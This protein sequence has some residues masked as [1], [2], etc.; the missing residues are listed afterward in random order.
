[1]NTMV[2][3]LSKVFLFISISIFIYIFSL[4]SLYVSHG[5]DI[6]DQ[7]FNLLNAMAPFDIFNA[8]SH[9]RYYTSMLYYLSGENLGLYRFFGTF[10]LLGI[11]FWF[12][13]ELHKYISEKLNKTFS[14]FE[15][16]TF[17]IPLMTSSLAFYKN[18]QITPS[19][20]WLA[21][22]SV[23][24]FFIS[25][26][27]IVRKKNILH[28]RWFSFDYFLL[29]FSLSLSFMAKPTTALVLA[30]IAILFLLYELKNIHTKYAITSVTIMTA[31]LVI[32]HIIFLDGGVSEYFSK[33][34]VGLERISLLGGG[35]T[36]KERFADMTEL[37]YAIYRELKQILLFSVIFILGLF[38][39]QK[40]GKNKKLISDR[41]LFFYFFIYAVFISQQIYDNQKLLWI[42]FLSF[43]LFALGTYV[44]Y[45]IANKKSFSFKGDKVEA[46]FLILIFL[47]V[48]GSIAYAF[49]TNNN[50]VSHM[51]KSIIF[52]SASILL[53]SHI[54]L[55]NITE[56]QI[57]ISFSG[58]V[59][60]CFV[61]YQVEQGFYKP[62]RLET[63]MN[64]QNYKIELQ[65]E[66][67][68]D[69]KH[70]KY[71]EDLQHIAKKYKKSDSLYLID[72]TGG[73]PAANIILDM[74]FF[75][76]PWLLG[77]YKGSNEFAYENL[78][79][80]K[81]TKELKTAWILTAPNGR[82]KLDLKILNMI[83]LNFP[84]DYKKIGIVKTAHRN[85]IQ[86][87]WKPND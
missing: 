66:I 85:E 41:F 24:L 29:S 19:Y 59:I 2:D 9:E 44:I 10:I 23:I 73:T 50:I 27:R 33:L 14:V 71:I 26:F 60:S 83:G 17:I 62:Y 45:L 6:T 54:Y 55:K 49:G 42:K 4:L 86:E 63:P 47:I 28:G 15:K 7:S 78:K 84:S 67:Y 11:S 8:I 69:K 18:W 13:I 37:F 30:F 20:N 43:L 82:R 64:E 21:L 32:G 52:L 31:L 77:A 53:F 81:D 75:S 16:L 51:S 70:K 12:A 57:F 48:L 35:H 46:K 79:S 58:M 34:S 72:L 36:L 76:A 65:G 5:F 74:K 25:L 61:L 68:V 87:L 40:Y 39:I 56:N 3:K 38:F 80:Y 1:M 22:I